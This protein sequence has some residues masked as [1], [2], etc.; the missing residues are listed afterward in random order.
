MMIGCVTGSRLFCGATFLEWTED[1]RHT[2]G[3]CPFYKQRT[4]TTILTACCSTDLCSLVQRTCNN[5]VAVGTSII[6]RS[7]FASRLV[8]FS[9]DCVSRLDCDEADRR[10]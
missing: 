7:L 6:I 8:L 4:A 9:I 1:D 2:Y 10:L 3:V 5:V